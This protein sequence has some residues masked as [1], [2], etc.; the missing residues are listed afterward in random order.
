MQDLAFRQLIFDEF[1]TLVQWAETEGWNP[2]LNDAELFWQTDPDGFYG[3][4]I[5][6]KL[7]G[8]GSI[9]S[10]SGNFGFMGFFIVSPEYRNAGIGKE[11]WHKRKN[12]LLSRLKPEATI[13]MDGVVS[14]QAFYAKGGFEIAFRDERYEKIGAAFPQ[15][16]QVSEVQIEDIDHLLKLD[17]VC[18]GFDRSPFIINWIQS[19]NAQ[20]FKY[21]DEEGFKGFAVLRKCVTG[22]KIGPLF[23]YNQHIASALYEKCLNESIGQPVYLDIPMANPMAIELVKKYDAKY[24]FECARMYL[25][26]APNV[27]LHKIFGVTTFELG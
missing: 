26:E 18:F 25:G 19:K 16:K 17:R 8:G 5:E 1:K 9:V 4:F 21:H 22:Y 6:K 3:C 10:Y 20:A 27:E 15:I 7:I 12:T 13:G 11:L 2:G 14:M 24:V 23:A